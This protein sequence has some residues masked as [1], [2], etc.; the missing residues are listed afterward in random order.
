VTQTREEFESEYN[1]GDIRALLLYGR[2]SIE[3]RC[4]WELCSGWK[5]THLDQLE[6]DL[7]LYGNTPSEVEAAVAH[8]LK[9]VSEFELEPKGKA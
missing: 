8:R 6:D 3:C 9:L 1:G 5:M 2:L 4:D 7:N